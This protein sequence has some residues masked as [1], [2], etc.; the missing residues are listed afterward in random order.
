MK[1]VI[2]LDEAD[3]KAIIAKHFNEK[4]YNVSLEIYDTLEGYGRDEVKVQKVKIKIETQT[5]TEI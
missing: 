3:I 2:I 5:Q 1:T 4:E